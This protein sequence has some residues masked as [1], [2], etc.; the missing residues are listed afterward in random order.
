MLSK[1]ITQFEQQLLMMKQ[2]YLS[3]EQQFREFNEIV[4]YDQNSVKKGWNEIHSPRLVNLILSICPQI[5][6]MMKILVKE[7]EMEPENKGNSSY[8][9]L[10]RLDRNNVLKEQIVGMPNPGNPNILLQ[11]FQ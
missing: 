1:I 11:P 10:N 8:D 9:Y 3:V 7:M 2:L 6:K 5:E 4:P